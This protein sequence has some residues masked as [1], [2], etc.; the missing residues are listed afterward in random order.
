MLHLIWLPL[1]QSPVTFHSAKILKPKTMS[2]PKH[3]PT[4]N[5]G[6]YLTLVNGFVLCLS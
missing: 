1:E 6:K 4:E 3:L 5:L 2:A